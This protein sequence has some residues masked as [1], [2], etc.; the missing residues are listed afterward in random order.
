VAHGAGPEHPRPLIL[1][2]YLGYGGAGKAT[3]CGRVL[4]DPRLRPALEGDRRWRNLVAF[5]KLMESDELPGV[6]VRASFQGRRYETVTDREGYFHFDLAARKDTTGW[7][8]VA[9]EPKATGCVL[10][11]STRARFGVISDID[12]TLVPSGAT[13]KLRMVIR[14]A[15]SNA[16]TRQPFEGVADF[17]RALHAGVN[18]IFYVSKSPWN[19]YLPLVEMMRVRGIPLGPLLLRDY[20]AHLVRRGR[21]E[22]K[23]LQ[24]DNILTTCRALPFVLIGD[25]GEHDPEIYSE[26]VRRHPGRIRVIYIRAIH[27]DN[28]RLEAIAQLAAQ[29]RRTDC[30]LVLV[31][32]TAYAA[33]HAAG[34]GLIRKLAAPRG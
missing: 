22:H 8:K 19:L 6:P 26:I 5:L 4:R 1:L 33:A 29:V 23:R 10:F 11:P 2:P 3:L 17:Y 18:P 12:D 32:D 15:L 7:Q 30:Q 13:K 24:I 27:P 28:A 34:E 21:Q 14:L 20:G 25:S 9:L 31:P 16:L